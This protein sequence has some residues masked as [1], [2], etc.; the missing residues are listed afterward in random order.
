MCFHS[1][2]DWV[3][4]EQQFNKKGT[5]AFLCVRDAKGVMI[6]GMP[7]NWADVKQMSRVKADLLSWHPRTSLDLSDVNSKRMAGGLPHLYSSHIP[8]YHGKPS[9]NVSITDDVVENHGTI[10]KYFKQKGNAYA[11]YA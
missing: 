3:E 4:Y 1:V 6:G 10:E 2:E 11:L 9:P 8:R 7:V 5:I